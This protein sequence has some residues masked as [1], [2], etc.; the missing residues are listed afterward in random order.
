GDAILSTLDRDKTAVMI[1]APD[2]AS[3]QAGTVP[4]AR[5]VRFDEVA[6]AKD[7]GRLP[8]LDHN[9][10]IFVAGKDAPEAR[11]AAQEIARNAFHNVSFFAGSMDDL[12]RAR[13][14][15]EAPVPR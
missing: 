5:N 12:M 10:R 9:T 6:K 14:P 1:D 7:D 2:P 15:S 3:F 11:A 4:G 8:M 13:P